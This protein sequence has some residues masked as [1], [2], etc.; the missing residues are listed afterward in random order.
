MQID[1][2]RAYILETEINENN[3][4][5]FKKVGKQGSKY[6]YSAI[7]EDRT[8]FDVTKDVVS[9]YS[10]NF[11]N[12]GLSN[13][14]NIYI[15]NK[16]P[17]DIVRKFGW[18]TR[19]SV[20]TYVHTLDVMQGTLKNVD[21][22][23][24]IEETYNHIALYGPDCMLCSIDKRKNRPLG[25]IRLYNSGLEQGTR[26]WVEYVDVMCGFIMY[27][28]L[29]YRNIQVFKIGAVPVNVEIPVEQFL[30]MIA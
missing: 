12:V 1:I 9:R 22:S 14:G 23:F 5:V 17:V 30:R 16:Y 27:S 21:K 11:L 13:D 24:R 3:N 29:P 19:K 4:E 8:R 20:T 15:K 6:I 28:K 26:K 7:A 10:L 2:S 25:T 18:Y